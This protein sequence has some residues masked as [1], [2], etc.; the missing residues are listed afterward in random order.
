MRELN[1]QELEQI[2]GGSNGWIFTYATQGQADGAAVAGI[3][4]AFS[5]STVA[6][7]H[8]PDFSRSFATNKSF[9][10]G[11]TAAVQ[12][13]AISASSSSIAGH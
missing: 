13:E 7:S 11:T 1:E 6:S 10:Y 3:G 2:T 4:I 9:A 12:S 5:K 8:G